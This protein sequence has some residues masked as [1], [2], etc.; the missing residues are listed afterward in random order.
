MMASHAIPLFPAR[1]VI[2]PFV[3]G[4]HTVYA[5]CPRPRRPS[6][7]SDWPSRNSVLVS[8]SLLFELVMA[9]KPFK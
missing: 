5:A 6:Q 8:K 7:L 9:P 3:Q 2:R 4:L 1:A